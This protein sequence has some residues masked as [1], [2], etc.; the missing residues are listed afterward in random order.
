[1]YSH[2]LQTCDWPRNVACKNAAVSPSINSIPASSDNTDDH[3]ADNIDI[4]LESKKV[5]LH[6]SITTYL[7]ENIFFP[8]KIFP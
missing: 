7:F 3:L 8:L 5:F 1:M 6:S 4:V 2:D